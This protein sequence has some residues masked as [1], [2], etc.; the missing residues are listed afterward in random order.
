MKSY[1]T[2]YS[3]RYYFCCHVFF[4]GLEQKKRNQHAVVKCGV[5]TESFERQ[6]LETKIF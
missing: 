1:E 3:Y 5:L 6:L 2:R 4:E